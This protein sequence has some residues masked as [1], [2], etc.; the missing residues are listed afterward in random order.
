MSAAPEPVHRMKQRGER[1]DSN[2]DRLDHKSGVPASPSREWQ[3]LS[4]AMQLDPKWTPPLLQQHR[5]RSMTGHIKRST[6]V[7]ATG[8]E[9]ATSRRPAERATKLRHAPWCAR[10]SKA[11]RP[12]QGNCQ[13]KTGTPG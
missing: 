13:I 11:F 6:L 7:G 9:P 10:Q 4:P 2:P 12:T 3:V 8:F 5:Y 1:G